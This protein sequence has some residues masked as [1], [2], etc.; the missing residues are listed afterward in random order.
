MP[1]EKRGAPRFV[2]RDR[3]LVCYPE[4]EP[5]IRDLS[6][7]GAFI[8]DR[9]PFRAGQTFRLRIPREDGVIDILAMVRRVDLGHGMGV[10]FL[11]MSYSSREH[12]RQL[13]T[14]VSRPA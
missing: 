9:R 14:H 1:E 4:F 5:I 11:E 10:E 7:A 3:I 6:E 8:E 2:A 12:L 13:V